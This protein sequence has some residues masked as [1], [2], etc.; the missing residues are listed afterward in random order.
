MHINEPLLL[1]QQ[2][3]RQLL[4]TLATTQDYSK[5]EEDMKYVKHRS[6]VYSHVN[7]TPFSCSEPNHNS[8]IIKSSYTTK[9][10]TNSLRPQP[11]EL[12]F[13]S[14]THHE[15]TRVREV[16]PGYKKI[17]ETTTHKNVNYDPC[18]LSNTQPPT[19]SRGVYK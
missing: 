9:S 7:I 12:K 18:E 5:W 4:Q 14:P 19:S 16:S 15:T 8:R 1:F 17:V 13:D 10:T 3:I 6:Q 2:T 11:R